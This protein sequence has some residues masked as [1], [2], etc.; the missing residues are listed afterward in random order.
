MPP[1]LKLEYRSNKWAEVAVALVKGG[2]NMP[3]FL[4]LEYRSNKW[5]E[6]AVALVNQ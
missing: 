5:A 2:E 3:P 6:V 1:F 4:K